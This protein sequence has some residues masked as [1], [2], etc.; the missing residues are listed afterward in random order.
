[1]CESEATAARYAAARHVHVS[2]R[3]HDHGHGPIDAAL[4]A[5]GLKREIA[6]V[7]DGFSAA[8]ASAG[9]SDLMATVH[10][11]RTVSLFAGMHS[12]ALPLPPSVEQFTVSLLW[13]PRLD[14]DPADRW[15]RE[16]VRGACTD[17]VRVWSADPQ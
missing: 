2:R 10:E 5:L 8:L 6:T 15:L 1:M 7:V 9:A 12:F 3:D 16:R 14:A 11:R 17:Q 4:A 13:H